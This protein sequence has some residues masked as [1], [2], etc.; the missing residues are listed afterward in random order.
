MSDKKPQKW[1]YSPKP[2]QQIKA[3]A[4]QKRRQTSQNA[5]GLM[6]IFDA[7]WMQRCI[8]VLFLMCIAGVPY[9]F[10]QMLQANN[11]SNVEV[12]IKQP[13]M[14]GFEYKR[15]PTGGG[16]S[17][18]Y[19]SQT[20]MTDRY[21]HHYVI[22]KADLPLAFPHKGQYRTYV[23]G[24]GQDLIN[25]QTLEPLQAY[26]KVEFVR[27]L[28]YGR[29]HSQTEAEAAIHNGAK[30]YPIE[31]VYWHEGEKRHFKRPVNEYQRRINVCSDCMS[32]RVVLQY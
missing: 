15:N 30:L 8:S 17:S 24:L 14:V 7:P 25:Q 23:N 2:L 26:M 5:S 21:Q 6:A 12:V 32:E 13:V 19:L 20:V 22:D 27:A 4:Q 1:V 29:R 31:M 16:K 10:Y 18:T 9:V 28:V 3:E 11:L